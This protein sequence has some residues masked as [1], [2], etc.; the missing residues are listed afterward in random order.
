MS[1]R[2][3][4][5]CCGPVE[6]EAPIAVT[7]NP[8]ARVSAV[9]TNAAIGEA[10]LGEWHTIDIAVF[11]EGF[12]AGSLVIEAEPARGIQLDLPVSELS[13]EHRQDTSLRIRLDTSA[14]DLTLTF[15]AITALGGLAKHSTIHFL[16]RSGSGVQSDTRASSIGG[17]IRCRAS[18][19]T[20]LSTSG[21]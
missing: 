16:V 14:V 9:R 6:S 19:D 11:N 10:K 12:V 21:L 2:A 13:G 3:S 17:E 7:I 4:A 8:E 15:R 5:G 20:G 18:I 1:Y